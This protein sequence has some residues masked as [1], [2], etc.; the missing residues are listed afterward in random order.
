V[1]GM[2]NDEDFKPMIKWI[3]RYFK[4]GLLQFEIS[5]LEFKKLTISHLKM[6]FHGTDYFILCEQRLLGSQIPS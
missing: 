6:K 4:C 5:H 1:N 3:M 2:D